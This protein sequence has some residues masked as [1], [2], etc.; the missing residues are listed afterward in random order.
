MATHKQFVTPIRPCGI[1][2]DVPNRWVP[3]VRRDLDLELPSNASRSDKF[4]S[5]LRALVRD[6]LRKGTGLRTVAL[7]DGVPIELDS[8][9]RG[10]LFL[11]EGD[12]ELFEGAR[13][14]I[15][16]GSRTCEGTIASI[17]NQ[18][19][20]ISLADDFGAAIAAC[21]LRIDNTAMIEALA[22]RLEKARCGE[23]RLN[24][25]I[26]DEVLENSGDQPESPSFEHLPVVISDLNSDQKR[27][28]HHTDVNRVTYLWGPPGTGK[29]QTLVVINELLFA[30]D[31][32]VLLC[33]NTN[34]AVDQVLT[35]L[36]EK[37]GISHPALADGK[38]VRIGKPDG[39]PKH[40]S[41]YVTLEGIVR[42]KSVDL[43]KSKLEL[44]GDAEKVRAHAASA[45][46][47]LAQFLA[48]DR[49]H[50]ER[51]AV[52]LRRKEFDKALSTI[53][54]QRV[55]VL[56][57]FAALERELSF[58]ANAGPLRRLLMRNQEVIRRD[59]TQCNA[60]RNNFEEMLRLKQQ[61]RNNSDLTRRLEEV[62]ARYDVL[63]E[64]LHKYDR[65]ATERVVTEFD[66]N[67]A[68][69]RHE[70][71]N[72]DAQIESI[73]QSIIAGARIVGATV[74][75]AFLSPQQ[76]G[77]FDTVIVDEASMVI[78]PALYYVC[79]LAK[80]KVIISGDFRQ[81]PPIVP[82]NQQAI[83]ETIG[84]DVFHAAGIPKAFGGGIIPKRTVML[85]EQY[86]MKA[87]ICDLISKRMYEGRLLT[88][89]NWI[90]PEA[91]LP[92]PFDGEMTIIDTSSIR[93][94]VSRFGTSRY[95]LM[96]ALVVR[97]LV[98]FLSERQA[99]LGIAE[100]P[101]SQLTIG[102]CT[103]FT[104]QKELLKRLVN[105]GGGMVGTVHHYQGDEKT[106]MI[107]DIPDSLGEKF[108]S[109]FAQAGGPDDPGSQ[110]FNVAVSR[111]KAHLIFVANLD[112]LDK[113]LPGDAFLRELLYTA[114]VRGRIVNVR[115]V[116]AM[117]PVIEDLREHGHPFD[118]E[119][120]A[121]ATGLFDRPSFDGVFRV[122]LDKAKKGIAIYSQFVTLQ[123]VGAYEALFR[124]KTLERVAIRCVTRPPA[125]NESIPADEAK[126]ALDSLE[127]MGCTVDTRWEIHQQVVI[128][129]DE[130]I[131]F[132]SLN[133]LSHT[134]G[135]DET[136]LRMISKPGALQMAA[137]LSVTGKI[138]PDRAEG[139]AFLGENP[140][141]PDCK[142]RTTYRMGKWGP[143]WE[144]ESR[145]GWTKSHKSS[146][147]QQRAT[148]N[149]VP[150]ADAPTCPKCESRTVLR[151]GRYGQF[152]GCS[153][154]PVCDGLV[155]EH[156][157][158]K[159]GTQ[160]RLAR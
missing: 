147:A 53:A 55:E 41:E 133:P 99:S 34:Q 95:N 65:V 16:V 26:A 72:I 127:S 131:W 149:E 67:E 146:R 96:N 40:L 128:V 117:W 82:T 151:R 126:E 70:I 19:L 140:K 68:H 123:R 63:V 97:N 12:A 33:S 107:I 132:G 158:R 62:S 77:N 138:S 155:K 110:L 6:M 39:I 153:R 66:K 31:K 111:A 88:S 21:V 36:C 89:P 122:D 142:A 134:S 49:A 30:A 18:S 78:L 124:R 5:A 87:G 116:I 37:F 120:K 38:V 14:T 90:A 148:K 50:E 106:A 125:Q 74:T 79:G 137:F 154:F 24:Y 15:S 108:V 85:A 60:K 73:A 101:G 23:A 94:F 160:T 152:W 9:D 129:D 135:T 2:P 141:C 61:E 43:H 76:F 139:L 22:D 93:P 28:V 91:E 42:R 10:Y 4:I 7:Q 92:A 27:A 17:S 20:T 113:K 100:L 25:S 8:R 105:K 104:A 150:L 47:I 83:L 1:L 144:C 44:Q 11:Y 64:S 103:P 84:C 157:D 52:E 86:R 29:T 13:V 102:I 98:R 75:K 112:Y 56:Q 3:P 145:C 143:Y 115:D 118:F 130:I 156:R 114:S 32:R 109:V 80:Q 58:R 69:L 121:L 57:Q 48:L 71:A 136:M 54:A 81:L 51:A 59:I 35:K 45:R 159:T 46:R 119:L